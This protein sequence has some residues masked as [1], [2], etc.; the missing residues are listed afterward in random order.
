MD[1]II[2]KGVRENNLNNVDIEIPRGKITVFT[3]V[4]GSGKST[5]AFD[6]IFA[7]GQRRY[8]ESLSSYAKQFVEKFSKPD[9]DYISGLSPSVSVDQKTFMRNPRSTV[10]TITEIYDFIRLAYSKL[11]TPK[12][13]ECGNEIVSGSVET[14]MDKLKKDKLLDKEIDIYYPISLGKKGEFKKEIEFAAK[15]FTIARLNGKTIEIKKIPHLDKQKKHNLEIYI[16]TISNPKKDI[17]RLSESLDLAFNYGNGVLIVESKSKRFIFNKKLTCNTCSISFP[18]ISPRLFSFN[19]PYGCCQ[20]CEGIGQFEF[21]DESLVV[22]ETKSISENAILPFTSL[23]PY[24][25]QVKDFAKKNSIDIKKIFSDLNKKDRNMILYGKSSS[26]L[27]DFILDYEVDTKKF[28]GVL[29]ILSNWLNYTK[30]EETR[31]VISKYLSIK[32]C[33]FCNGSRL[34]KESTNIFIN[35]LNISEFCSL[36]ISDAINFIKKVKFEKNR[37]LIWKKIQSEIES[38]LIFLKDVGLSYLT[39]DRSAPTLSGG[40]AQRIRLATQLGAN[41]TG[42]TYVLDEPTI[43]LHPRDNKKLVESLKALK[44][45]GN[46]VLVVEHD[47][48]TIKNADNIID[49]G[50]KAGLGGGEIVYAGDLKGIKKNKKSLTG[51]YLSGKKEILKSEKKLD[52]NFNQISISNIKKNNL[53]DINI[54][55]PVGYITCVTGVSGSGK[56]SLVSQTISPLLERII[57]NPKRKLLRPEKIKGAEHLDKIISIDQSP[58]GRTSRS[59]P[60]TYTGIFS[61]IREIFSSMQISRMKGYGPGR[62]S[63]N[64][65]E[66]SCQSCSGAGNIKIEM[67]FL[68]DVLVEC[69]E[70]NGNRFDE[71]TLSIYYNGKNI[72]DVLNMTFEE[73]ESF[74]SGFPIL[75]SKI[76]ILN[77]V[78]LHY[79][80]L[81]QPATTLSGGEAQRVK[82]SKELIKKNTGKTFYILDEPTIGLHYHDVNNLMKVL[83]KLRDSGATILIVEHNLD[84]VNCSDY[85]IDLGPEGG[86]KGGFLQFSGSKDIFLKE[87]KSETAVYLRDHIKHRN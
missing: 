47:E 58:I 23:A 39:L 80:K 35:K 21:I 50:P 43:G 42:V 71:E 69:D 48:D 63:F 65:K 38:R 55:I 74:F 19:S 86:D 27:S 8:L 54:D 46:T 78:G 13:F 12:C 17:K 24:K 4:S 70:C 81:G 15:L 14:I 51:D 32:K 34:R 83:Y 40:E 45:K 7:E 87:S 56:S 16:D 22:D 5:L 52:K 25:K 77:S 79:L 66:G 10:A 59:N 37:N 75:K 18:E 53:K 73:A 85:I 36:N 3:G 67:S 26:N 61:T 72:S 76:N 29:N 44:N 11:G 1:K 20:H 9:L 62:F 28:T 2:A 31:E 84:V 57:L 49:I 82:L 30:S 6:T 68:P 33:K 60:V 64:V 41:L